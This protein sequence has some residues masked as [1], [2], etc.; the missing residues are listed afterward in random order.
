MPLFTKESLENLRQRIDLVDVLSAHMD[1][2]RAGAAYKGLCPFHDEKTP[3]FMIQK[4]DTHYHCFG[5]GAHGDAIQFLMAHLKMGFSE[6]VENL[7]ERFH[8]PLELLENNEADKGPSKVLLKEALEQACRFYHFYLLHTQEGHEV[9]QYLYK[10]GLDLDFIRGFHIGLSPK[11]PGIFRKMMHAKFIKDETLAAAGLI[12]ESKEGRWRDFFSERIMFPIRDAAGSVIGFSARRFKEE[13]F[14][15]KYINTSETALFKKS[16]IL[17]G[18]NYSRRRIAKENKAIVVE[19]QIDALR[20]IQEGFNF[21]VAGQGTAFG[22]GHAKELINLGVT[23]IYL[24]LDGDSAGREA[25]IKI[26]DLFQRE[27]VEVKVVQM[28]Q[29]LDPDAFLREKG[30]DAFF[31]LLDQAVEYLDFLV[32]YHSKVYGSG[33][34]AAKHQ[35]IETIAKQ[36]RT[37]NSP[38]MVHESLRKLAHLTQVAENTLLLE[39]GH[40]PN[41]YIKKAEKIGLQTIDPDRILELD[42]LRW[43]FIASDQRERFLM[44][45]QNHLKNDDFRHPICRKLYHALQEAFSNKTSFDALSLILTMDEPEGQALISELFEKKINKEKSDAGFLEALQKILNRNWMERCEA[46]KM[47][48]QSGQCQDDEALSLVKEYNDLRKSP[49]QILALER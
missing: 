35:L 26:G 38:I 49:P 8:V 12:A 25:T 20:L 15:G 28:P 19:G 24:A 4:G 45:L 47:K 48:I 3:S 14:G 40:T 37:W 32:K 11:P 33:S 27:G 23:L 7:A 22:E 18:L 30:A 29:G 31:A 16:R 2:K 39:Q 17:F 13:T 6:A 10:R 1:L 9:L 21:T 36:I 34:P 44:A 46:I 5:C 42:L 43:I 41:L